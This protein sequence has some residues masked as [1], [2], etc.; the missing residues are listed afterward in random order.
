[1]FQNTRKAE[2]D[3]AVSIN[4]VTWIAAGVEEHP[5]ELCWIGDSS[6]KHAADRVGVSRNIPA[7]HAGDVICVPERMR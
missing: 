7:C 2:I 4:P 6:F 3:V 5:V 1:M